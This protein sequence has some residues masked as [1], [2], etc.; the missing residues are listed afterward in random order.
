MC[1]RL[2]SVLNENAET[3]S[4]DLANLKKIFG[5]EIKGKI[6]R[7]LIMFYFIYFCLVLPL[8]SL[9]AIQFFF[10]LF[11]LP[12]LFQ[13]CVFCHVF[14]LSKKSYPRNTSSIGTDSVIHRTYIS[15]S[16]GGGGGGA[17]GTNI[18]RLFQKLLEEVKN[19]CRHYTIETTENRNRSRRLLN[20]C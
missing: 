4:W 12:D 20:M 7:L 10:R 9:H 16:C 15:A 1:K 17:A 18:L 14:F 6:A 19:K 3:A 5:L 13:H 2:S 11:W 8:Q